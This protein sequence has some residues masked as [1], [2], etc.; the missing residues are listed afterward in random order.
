MKRA[1]IVG[2]APIGRIG[3][4]RSYLRADDT[5]IYCDGGPGPI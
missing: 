3:S 1:V 4:I 5:M 2:G